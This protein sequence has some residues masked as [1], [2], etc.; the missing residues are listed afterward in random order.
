MTTY[1]WLTKNL[2][3]QRVSKLKKMRDLFIDSYYSK[4]YAQEGE[5]MILKRL[6][7]RQKKGFFIDVGS[8]HPK[9]FSN[10]YFFYKRG[11]RGI[12][13]DA[14]P[15]SME[16][17]KKHRK[18]DI[19]LEVAVSDKPA[20]LTY[21]EFNEP[22]LNGFS[23]SLSLQR[24][25][26][27]NYKIINQYTIETQTLTKVLDSVKERM[28]PEIDFISIDVEGLDFQVIKSLDFVKYQPKVILVEILSKSLDE[29]NN[30]EIA[31][32]LRQL[33]YLVYAKSINTV[34]FVH[35]DF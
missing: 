27:E 12:N 35:R 21:Y 19:N 11:W 23:E 17:F 6:F 13:I 32:Y 30:H 31:L 2:S 34:F 14:M 18:R 24:D 5:D 1:K 28:P 7:E 20:K 33:D 9:R 26:L 3:H 8:H 22:A 10:T 16:L 29:I 4:S 15:K 25:G